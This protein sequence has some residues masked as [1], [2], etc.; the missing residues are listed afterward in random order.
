MSAVTQQLLLG[1]GAAVTPISNTFTAVSAS[2]TVNRTTYT[3]TGLSI[4]AADAT[5]RVI[6]AV[7]WDANSVGGQTISSATI[8][9][10]SA[11][12]HGTAIDETSGSYVQFISALVPTGTTATVSVTFGGGNAACFV[13]VW[14]QIN[15][16][17]STPFATQ[18]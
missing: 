11:T 3:F 13:A 12:I 8:G 9:G 2:D 15:E 17:S 10:V 14:R 1:Y 5:R 16:S 18:S 4:G 7:H 6:C